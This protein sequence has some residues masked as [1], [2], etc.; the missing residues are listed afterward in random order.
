MNIE[1]AFMPAES[2]ACDDVLFLQA[3]Q[4]LTSTAAASRN[5]GQQRRQSPGVLFEQLDTEQFVGAQRQRFLVFPFLAHVFILYGNQ[6][7]AST[8]THWRSI[9]RHCI[10]AVRPR[11]LVRHPVSAF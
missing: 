4:V 9:P 10:P 8:A 7:V 6:P 3:T 11:T 1:L 2:V 5:R